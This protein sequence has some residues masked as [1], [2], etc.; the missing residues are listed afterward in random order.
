M[1][2]NNYN[3]RLFY[4]GQIFEN[5]YWLRNVTVQIDTVKAGH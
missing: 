3:S 1:V 4:N 5:H 2:Y